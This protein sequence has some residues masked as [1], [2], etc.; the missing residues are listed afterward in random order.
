MIHLCLGNITIPLPTAEHEDANVRSLSLLPGVPVA[1]IV[2]RY[3]VGFYV[4]DRATNVYLAGG[5]TDD[6]GRRRPLIAGTTRSAKVFEDRAAA[7]RAA[8]Y[9]NGTR[10]VSWRGEWE[11]VEVTRPD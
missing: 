10:R 11:V 9:L 2:G 7:E 1:V 6:Q 5:W 3:E 8:A 4:R